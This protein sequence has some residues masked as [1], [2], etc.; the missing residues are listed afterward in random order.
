MTATNSIAGT[1]SQFLPNPDNELWNKG[2]SNSSGF[3]NTFDLL[4]SNPDLNFFSNSSSTSANTTAGGWG[5]QF[6]SGLTNNINW[7]DIAKNAANNI[8]N[9]LPGVSGIPGMLAGYEMQPN[10]TSSAM[11]TTQFPIAKA[12]WD[13]NLANQFEQQ[14]I[15]NKIGINMADVLARNLSSLQNKASAVEG[16]RLNT[17]SPSWGFRTNPEPGILA[18]SKPVF[19]NSFDP[20]RV[21]SIR[22]YRTA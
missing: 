3:A 21:A 18:G 17:G 19:N 12:T 16:S 22:G 9:P 1:W 5:N 10:T 8:F 20:S 14:L 6:L 4:K 13:M 11:A 2:F 15:N 7:G